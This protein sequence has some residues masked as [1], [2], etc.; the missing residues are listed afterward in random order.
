MIFYLYQNESYL[1]EPVYLASF[2]IEEDDLDNV[3]DAI[4][5]EQ[6]FN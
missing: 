4:E 3:L 5:C 6:M 2:D 1:E